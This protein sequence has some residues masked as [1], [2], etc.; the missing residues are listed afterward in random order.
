MLVA[1]FGP[2]TGWAGRTITFYEGSFTLEGHGFVTARDV[3]E[4]DR[5]GHLVWAY[6]GLREWA[7]S[8]VPPPAAAQPAYLPSSP[9]VQTPVATSPAQAPP[10]VQ[11]PPLA[12]TVPSQAAAVE[13]PPAVTPPASGTAPPRELAA[14]RTPEGHAAAGAA[15]AASGPSGPAAPAMAQD[16]WRAQCL[17]FDARVLA[18]LAGP[19]EP[20]TGDLAQTARC[21]C[22][23]FPAAPEGQRRAITL[24][25]R[26]GRPVHTAWTGPDAALP[27]EGQAPV[28]RAP[29]AWIFADAPWASMAV[30]PGW[31]GGAPET[32][33]ALA[34]AQLQ[35]R[36]P[37]WTAWT[38]EWLAPLKT[39][40]ATTA[41]RKAALLFAVDVAAATLDDLACCVLLR[42]E[43][44]ATQQGATLEWRTDD[45]AR[46]L[47]TTG[48]IESVAYG[49]FAGRPGSRIVAESRAAIPH[50]PWAIY[51]VSYVFLSL[52]YACSLEFT[53]PSAAL[54]RLGEADRCA[55]TFVFKG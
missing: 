22:W 40:Y 53:V 55:S 7:C 49:T 35:A 24:Y 1:T 43:L 15:A 51:V 5:Q 4:Y 44:D 52:P 18:A 27:A 42:E 21:I 8:L 17:D 9:P 14:G 3:L 31:A 30:P 36:G 16:L 50:G 19:G 2:T 11:T 12:Q 47:G 32:S 6:D 29:A 23:D 45:Q 37:D 20:G 41:G 26:D 13:T 38:G 34:E 54:H 33:G 28:P 10:P 25:D 46:R 39:M 48:L